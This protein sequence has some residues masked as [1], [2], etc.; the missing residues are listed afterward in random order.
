M[1]LCG[2]A[3]WRVCA[4][5][6]LM[7]GS[8]PADR[9]E[10]VY[11]I[12]GELNAIERAPISSVID[13][14]QP[15]SLGIDMIKTSVSVSEINESRAMM[16]QCHSARERRTESLAVAGLKHEETQFQGTL[17]D[18]ISRPIFA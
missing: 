9:F 17:R 7:Q 6:N 3:R 2:R 15:F 11:I 18:T 4:R 14:A 1:M 5:F 10:P 12:R 13:A 8:K 16:P